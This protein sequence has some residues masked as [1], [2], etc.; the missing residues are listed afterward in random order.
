[1]HAV[2]VLCGEACEFQGRVICNDTNIVGTVLQFCGSLTA[3]FI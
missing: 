3:E 2:L 1:M